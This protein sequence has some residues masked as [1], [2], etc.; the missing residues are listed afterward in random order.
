MISCRT[1]TLVGVTSNYPS[2]MPRSFLGSFATNTA[3]ALESREVCR[4]RLLPLFM[5][6]AD[7]FGALAISRFQT[8]VEVTRRSANLN[9]R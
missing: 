7:T 3:Q 5:T 8:P 4:Q 1:D 6:K 9:A 2:L